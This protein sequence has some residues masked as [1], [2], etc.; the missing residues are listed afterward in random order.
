MK[1]KEHIL[2]FESVDFL[3]K[4]RSNSGTIGQLDDV[5][6]APRD[7]ANRYAIRLSR[8]VEDRLLKLGKVNKKHKFDPKDPINKAAISFYNKVIID[9]R[10]VREWTEDPARV[11]KKLHLD[12]SN[13]VIVR[14]K[15]LEIN[16]LIDTNIISNPCDIKQTVA[17]VVIAII[18]VVVLVFVPSSSA[19]NIDDIVVDP[20]TKDK[21]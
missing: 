14:I 1:K 7:F 10:F 9:G 5:L 18:I 21:V 13:E 2:D 6:T 11:A 19:Y 15:E 4:A 17:V 12:V 16:N 20:K 8:N 3:L